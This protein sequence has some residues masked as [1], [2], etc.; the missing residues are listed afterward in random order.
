MDLK[1][2]P[3]NFKGVLEKARGTKKNFHLDGK[4]HVSYF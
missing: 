2:S 4:I 3:A 1:V